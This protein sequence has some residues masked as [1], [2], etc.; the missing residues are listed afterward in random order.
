MVPGEAGQQEKLPTMHHTHTHTPSS[1]VRK[2]LGRILV[3]TF[4]APGTKM[5]RE[6]AH[7]G[8]NLEYV[9]RSAI[10]L[11]SFFPQHKA[12]GESGRL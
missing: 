9:A 11:L 3:P 5:K 2:L 10:L 7:R 6:A 4:L 1:A 8:Q 12:K